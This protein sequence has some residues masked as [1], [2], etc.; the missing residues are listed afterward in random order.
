MLVGFVIGQPAAA[1]EL[2]GIKFF[3]RKNAQNAD[4]VIG[5][6]QNYTVDFDVTGAESDLVK[7]LKGASSLWKNRNEPASGGAG[8]IAMARGDYQRLLAALYGPGRYGGT[9]SILVDGREAAN[10]PPDAATRRPRIGERCGQSGTALPFRKG[11]HHQSSATARHRDD[12]VE[13]PENKGFASG[14]VAR[15]GVILQAERLAVEAWR[16]QGH[17]KAERRG[18]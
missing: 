10:L 3:E 5:E 1:F 8:L 7:A 4:D 13:L 6:P 11:E 14:E 16:Q 17:A 15:S 9:I 18:P 12:K 2:F